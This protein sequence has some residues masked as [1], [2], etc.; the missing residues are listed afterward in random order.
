VSERKS[1]TAEFCSQLRAQARSPLPDEV[2]AAGRQGFLNVLGTA[3]AASD[4]P[5][6][7]AI[8]DVAAEH[9]GEARTPIPGRTERADVVT[10]PLA[11]GFAA[12]LDDFD[13]THLATVIHPGAATMAASW[14]MGIARGAS[15]AEVLTAFALGCE[16]QL[17]V[18]VAMS[19]AHYD[20]GWHIT[21][22]CGGIGAAVAAGLLAGLD[23]DRLTA[24]V[25]IAASSTL[26]LREAFGTMTKPYHPGK[27]ATNGVL[28][29]LLAEQGLSAPRDVL[30]APRGFFAVLSPRE[31][32]PD[33]ILHG[34]G[35]RW[36]LLDNT[37]KPYPCGIVSHPA[38]DAAVALA[39]RVGTDGE[40]ER[41]VAR[42]HPLVPEL[43]GNMDPKD[44]L[45]AR[46]STAHGI[47]AGLADGRVGLPQ[48]AD[49]RV[50]DDDVT[51]LRSKV[52]YEVDPDCPR[53]QATVTVQLADGSTAT[54]H[55]EHARGS[56]ARPLD[57][58]E[59]RAKVRALVEPVLPGAS[60]GLFAAVADLAQHDDL[61][62]LVAACTPDSAEVPT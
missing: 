17:R 1:L 41:I 58:E 29:A 57:D 15:G 37:F 28:A 48:Y 6:T 25:G 56:L 8:L 3:I 54:E 53:D 47:A 42:V 32:D 44:G 13:D 4:H 43:T 22:T 7:S 36:E 16:A 11:I 18:G 9:G 2:R 38:I 60:D 19:P 62:Q 45:Q 31:H 26:G 51:A 27:A 46:F 12:H 39:E 35:S 21:G 24:A 59:L 33:S 49:D 52:S 10:A 30:R 50:R 61:R 14:S 20:D 40:V 55:V 23:D 34:L 5:G